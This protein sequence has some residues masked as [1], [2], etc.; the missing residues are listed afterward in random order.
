MRKSRF[1]CLALACFLAIVVI[2]V[3]DGYLGVYDSAT[4]KAGEFTQEIPAGSWPTGSYPYSVSSQSDQKIFFTYRIDNRWFT[5]Y[6]K[7]VIVSLW[8]QNQKVADLYSQTLEIQPFKKA[9]AEWTADP[10]DLN[11]GV[12]QQEQFTVRIE[13]DGSIREVIIISFYLP[14]T[15]TGVPKAIPVPPPIR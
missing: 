7:T 3:F 10:A 12:F 9:T 5:A 4:I 13:Q 1:F 6:R 8:Q 2:F 15:E 14:V 11:L